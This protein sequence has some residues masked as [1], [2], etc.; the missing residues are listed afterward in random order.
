MPKGRLSHDQLSNIVIAYFA[1]A[2]DIAELN[3]R[4]IFELEHIGCVDSD[5]VYVI[6]VVWALSTLQFTFPLTIAKEVK[7]GGRVDKVCGWFY[8]TETWTYFIC[9]LL[10]DGPFLAV[11]LY[12]LVKYT[13]IFR[14]SIVVYM[15]KNAIMILL[16]IYRAIAVNKTRRKSIKKDKKARES[17]IDLVSSRGDTSYLGSMTSVDT[18]M[19]NI[20]GY[21]Q[22]I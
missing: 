9:V 22:R 15:G 7:D 19:T 11:R 10:Q 8:E 16:Q 17:S 5:T 20:E 13:H 4:E 18:D 12:C 3:V 14:P 6:L 21:Y 2:F 1:I